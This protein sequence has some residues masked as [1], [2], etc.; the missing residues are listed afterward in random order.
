V[1]VRKPQAEQVEGKSQAV[2]AGGKAAS[3]IA[4]RSGNLRLWLFGRVS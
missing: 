1:E 3:W 2:T 4:D